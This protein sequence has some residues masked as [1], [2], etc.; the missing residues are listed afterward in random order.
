LAD[1]LAEN[2]DRYGGWAE[3]ELRADV[4]IASDHAHIFHRNDA[5]LCQF[6]MHVGA[7]ITGVMNLLSRSDFVQFFL[8]DCDSLVNP[9]ETLRAL[10]L[11]WDCRLD[12]LA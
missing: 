12:C 4:G 11:R 3:R 9:D 10:R 1:V 8:L 2:T 5:K 7:E 6:D